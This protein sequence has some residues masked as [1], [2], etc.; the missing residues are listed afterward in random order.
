MINGGTGPVLAFSEIL[1]KM[2]KT[3]DVPFLAFNAWIGI[4]VT[5]YMVI[6]AFVDLNRII[7]YATRFTDEIFSLLIAAIFII[8]ALGSPNAP[9]GVFHYFNPDH[10]SHSFHED[11]DN[12]S[13][14]ASALLSLLLCFGTVEMSFI[15]RRFKF[16]PFFPNQLIRDIITD[17]AVVISILVMSAIA[18]AIDT[19]TEK[20]NVPDRIAPTFAC[21]TSACD[22]SWPEQCPELEVADGYR[23]WLVN[24]F[25]LNGKTWVPFMAA[26]PAILA[27]VS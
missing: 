9:I 27:F 26:G 3:I 6:A 20:L 14:L 11:D 2:S 13:Y 4:W 18:F 16:S 22:K 24:I 7:V 10:E 19:P 12:Y 25:D 21:C 17:F 1:Y 23:P 8:N 15:L 5:I